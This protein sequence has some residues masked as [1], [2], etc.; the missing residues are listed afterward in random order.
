M[1]DQSL[2][3][4][5]LSELSDSG[6]PTQILQT[7]RYTDEKWYSGTPSSWISAHRAAPCLESRT[8]SIERDLSPIRVKRRKLFISSASF[9]RHGGLAMQADYADGMKSTPIEERAFW[10]SGL[11]AI[12]PEM[13]LF[14]PICGTLA[15]KNQCAVISRWSPA[16]VRSKR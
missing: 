11:A 9:I 1:L 6:L 16:C 14:F 3:E 7:A 15:R 12:L 13:G 8:I 4:A 10:L 5:E 2:I